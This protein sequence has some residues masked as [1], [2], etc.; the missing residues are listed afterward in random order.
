MRIY[1][2]REN[3]MILPLLTSLFFFYFFFYFLFNQGL[4]L[5]RTCNF[6]AH[7]LSLVLREDIRAGSLSHLQLH[8]VLQSTLQRRRQPGAS[9]GMQAAAD[10]VAFEGFGHV[11][12]SFKGNHAKILGG[13]YEAEGTACGFRKRIEH[14]REASISRE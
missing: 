1:F 9:S 12:S 8:R 2:Y 5:I 4:T 6:Q 7:T 10:P 13:S 3:I 11:F 14:L